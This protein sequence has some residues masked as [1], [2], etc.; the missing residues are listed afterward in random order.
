LIITGRKVVDWVELQ[1]GE[2]YAIGEGVGIVRNG[3]IVAGV[4][5]DQF[6]NNG[7]NMHVAS[8]SDYWFTRKFAAV[9]FGVPFVQWGYE[10]VTAPIYSDNEKSINFVKRIGFVHEGTLRGHRPV[11]IYGLLKTESRWQNG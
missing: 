3:E 11:S 6:T 4:V 9:A 10:R 8:I 1:L 7:C 5:Y 2:K